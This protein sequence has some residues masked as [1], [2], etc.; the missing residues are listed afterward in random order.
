MMID[1]FN[2]IAKD[3]LPNIDYNMAFFIS[4]PLSGLGQ[5]LTQRAEG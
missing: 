2:I 4:D 1:L 5:D 3:I